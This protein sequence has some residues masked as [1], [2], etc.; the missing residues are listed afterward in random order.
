MSSEEKRGYIEECTELPI[1]RQCELLNISRSTF[2]YTP[3]QLSELDLLL[4]KLMDIEYTAHPYYGSRRLKIHL[5][6]L[7][8]IVSRD[9]VRG[10]MALMNLEAIYPKKKLTTRNPDH[11]IYPYLL[12]DQKIIRP[13]QVWSTDIT[14]IPMKNGFLYLV[15][16]IDWFS[17]Y[18]LSWNLSNSLDGLFCREAVAAALKIGKPDIFNVDQGSQFT[19]REFVNLIIGNNIQLSMDGRGRCLDNI[20]IER[21]W[22]SLKY[23]EVYLKNYSNGN[24]ASISIGKYFLHYNED[25]PHQSLNYSTPQTIYYT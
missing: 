12:R 24:D 2:Y 22:R 20:F 11:I 21:L 13:N 23:E 18:V 8:H 19:C 9:K 15:A 5:N 14:Y 3:C 17:R 4:M 25:R 10:L 6:R 7:G 16:V 1:S